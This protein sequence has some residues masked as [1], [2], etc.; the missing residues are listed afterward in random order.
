[1]AKEEDKYMLRAAAG[2][3]GKFVD[4]AVGQVADSPLPTQQVHLQKHIIYMFRHL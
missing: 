4:A 2:K 3:Q 1:V